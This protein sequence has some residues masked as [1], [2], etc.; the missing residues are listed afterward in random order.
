[1]VMKPLIRIV[2]LDSRNKTWENKVYDENQHK[3]NR[4]NMI[5]LITDRHKFFKVQIIKEITMKEEVN[6]D[7]TRVRETR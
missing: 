4:Q 2:S 1:M 3:N 5:G 6:L 7:V